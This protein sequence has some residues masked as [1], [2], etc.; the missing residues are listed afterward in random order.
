MLHPAVGELYCPVFMEPAIGEQVRLNVPLPYLKTADPMPML[1]PS[2][3]ISPDEFG[4]VVELRAK[5]IA[6]V[7]FRQ[8]TFLIPLERLV[9]L[10]DGDS[11]S[12]D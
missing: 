12:G 2:D 3:L 8:G 6:A 1:R 7:R 10:S 9:G 4:E 5:G 11:A